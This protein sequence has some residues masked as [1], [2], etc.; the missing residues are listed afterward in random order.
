MLQRPNFSPGI[1]KV[2]S[3]RFLAAAQVLMCPVKCY[4]GSDGG[5]GDARGA[6]LVVVVVVCMST[7]PPVVLLLVIVLAL[8]AALHGERVSVCVDMRVHVRVAQQS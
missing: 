8:G 6:M 3:I 1:I 5:C 2:G 7:P 4:L